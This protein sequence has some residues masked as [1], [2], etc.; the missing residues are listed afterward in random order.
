MG[1]DKEDIAEEHTNPLRVSYQGF[2]KHE[3]NDEQ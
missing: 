3:G 1:I 2:R